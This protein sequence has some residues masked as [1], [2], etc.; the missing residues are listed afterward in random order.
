MR[1]IALAL[2]LM[3]A[4]PVAANEPLPSV[5]VRDPI[6]VRPTLGLPVPIV[7]VQPAPVTVVVADSSIKTIDIAGWLGYHSG[8]QVRIAVKYII[9]VRP[10]IATS[11]TNPPIQLRGSAI[12]VWPEGIFYTRE[13][14]EALTARL[15]SL[16][17]GVDISTLAPPPAD[18]EE[19]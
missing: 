11:G 15:A 9:Y 19:Q 18:K 2:L 12:A 16:G 1:S 14:P 17:W 13:L 10:H 6:F 8:D 7:N 5:I 4:A 3:I